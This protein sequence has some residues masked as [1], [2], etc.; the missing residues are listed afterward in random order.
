[1]SIPPELLSP[2][3]LLPS[4]GGG[5]LIGASAALLLLGAG[6]I[7]GIS[8]ILHS[9][10]AG[11]R[12]APRTAF[13][14]GLL[15]TAAMAAIVAPFDAHALL[16]QPHWGK[17]LLAGLLVGIGTRVGQGC[18]SGHGVCGIANGSARSLAATLT[19]MAVAALVVA[20]GFGGLS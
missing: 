9:V 16:A 14:A 10:V 2:E 4:I 8:G 15:L 5:L 13:L 7:A 19:F 18:T 6:R 11:P 12:S 3:R 1:M 17:L 20:L